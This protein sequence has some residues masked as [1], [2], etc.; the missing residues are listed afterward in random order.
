MEML[1][2]IVSAQFSRLRIFIVSRL[3]YVVTCTITE[4]LRLV[5]SLAFQVLSKI[6]Q[7]LFWL[8]LS[9]DGEVYVWD[10]N[11]RKCLNRF[12][13][14]GSLYGLSIATSRNGQ[15]VACG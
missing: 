5:S 11:S 6:N 14:E 1:Q 3:L 4:G 8:L 2:E 10:V 12:V 9:A 15:Y 13:D 7:T